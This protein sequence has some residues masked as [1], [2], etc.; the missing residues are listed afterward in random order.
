MKNIKLF[1]MTLL[2]SPVC[3]AA[4]GVNVW[5]TF[6][7][8]MYRVNEALANTNEMM[9]QMDRLKARS[10]DDYPQH[11]ETNKPSGQIHQ[12][13]ESRKVHLFSGSSSGSMNNLATFLT[14]QLTHNRDLNNIAESRIAVTSFVNLEN[15]RETNKIGLSLSELLIHKL[16]ISGFKVVDFKAMG[17]IVILPTGDFVFSRNPAD[18]KNEYNIHYFLTG[19]LTKTLEGIVV[20]A[21]LVNARTSLV[22]SSAQAFIPARDARKLMSEYSD[23]ESERVVI[24]HLPSPSPNMVKLK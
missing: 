11:S 19:T 15:L 22:A 4:G 20:N 24:R 10:R 2:F 16:Q 17:E 23:G 5:D 3:F 13:M 21:R 1:L 14:E 6:N 9:G 8:N 12:S 18:L 7:N